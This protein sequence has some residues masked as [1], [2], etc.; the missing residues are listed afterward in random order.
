MHSDR[1]WCRAGLA[2]ANQAMDCRSKIKR[3]SQQWKDTQGTITM[4]FKKKREKPWYESTV[5]K[6]S[7]KEAN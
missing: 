5:K 3:Q 4:C 7:Q 1:I 6:G 2:H